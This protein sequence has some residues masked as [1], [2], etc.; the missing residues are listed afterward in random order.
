MAPS[1]AIASVRIVGGSTAAPPPECDRYRSF[2]DTFFTPTMRLSSSSSV[3]RSTKRNGE[4]CGRICSIAALS[5]GSVRSIGNANY[6]RA[7]TLTT[8]TNSH[9]QLT[10]LFALGREVASVLDLE[11]LLHKIP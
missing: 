11:E 4:R 5:R 2:S 8:V 1:C 9:E 10:T 3:T 6:T 7:T